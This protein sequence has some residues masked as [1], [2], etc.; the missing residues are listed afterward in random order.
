M[1][2]AFKIGKGVAWQSY[3]AV[4]LLIILNRCNS[5][6][7]FFRDSSRYILEKILKGANRNEI[8]LTCYDEYDISG[9]EIG[10]QIDDFVD[11]L[12]QEGILD[13]W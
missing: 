11:L 10:K 7:Y 3:E 8:I 12:L 13:E 5:Q 1:S 6:F 9:E 4:D 2:V